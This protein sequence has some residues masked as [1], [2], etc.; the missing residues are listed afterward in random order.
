MF[1]FS[2]WV[3]DDLVI[4]ATATATGRTILTVIATHASVTYPTSNAW[5]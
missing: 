5:W 1:W 3:D 2:S 4:A